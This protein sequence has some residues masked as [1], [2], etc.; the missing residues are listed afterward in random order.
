MYRKI[1]LFV[2]RMVRDFFF[3]AGF[4]IFLS[5]LG[6]PLFSKETILVD[7]AFLYILFEAGGYKFFYLLFGTCWGIFAC[8]LDS[9]ILLSKSV[10]E[11]NLRK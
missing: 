10:D 1:L 5:L 9:L 7:S 2:C 8:F 3:G 4:F 6:V 11:G